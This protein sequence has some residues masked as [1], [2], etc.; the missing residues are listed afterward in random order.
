MVLRNVAMVFG[1]T[2][3]LPSGATGE[4]DLAAMNNTF[5]VIELLCKQVSHIIHDRYMYHI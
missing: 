3:M 2:L 1:P 4:L 5:T